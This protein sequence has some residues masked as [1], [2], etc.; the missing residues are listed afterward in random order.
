MFFFIEVTDTFGGEA[1]YSWVT[2]HV[3]KGKSMLGAVHRFSKLSGLQWR[4][5]CDHGDQKRYDSESGATCYFIEQLSDD[6][7][8]QAESL[9]FHSLN[10][11]DRS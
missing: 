3:I 8:E 4:K 7:D 2:R 1:N 9:K 5:V 10:T 6:A 11:D